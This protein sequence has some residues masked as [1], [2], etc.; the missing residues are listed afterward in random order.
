MIRRLIH[1]PR[2]RRAHME[3][4]QAHDEAC[5][6]GDTRAMHRTRQRLTRALHEVMRLEVRI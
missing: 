4:Q 2:A 5:R 6:R 3:A 1:L